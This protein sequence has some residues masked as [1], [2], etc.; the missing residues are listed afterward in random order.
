MLEGTEQIGGSS[1]RVRG[2]GLIGG[3]ILET[4]EFLRGSEGS[5]AGPLGHGASESSLLQALLLVRGQRKLKK[6]NSQHGG[7]QQEAKSK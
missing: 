5:G 3:D 4:L 2:E 1:L 6:T 7:T